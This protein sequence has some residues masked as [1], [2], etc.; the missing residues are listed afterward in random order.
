MEAEEEVVHPES[1]H[2]N[3][4]E[5][6]RPLMD[7]DDAQYKA[8]LDDVVNQYAMPLIGKIIGSK[9]K[10]Y[11]AAQFN[12]AEDFDVDDLCQE[13]VTNL[14]AYLDNW[15][16]NPNDHVIND[17]ND[18]VAK[19]AYNVYNSYLRRKYPLRHSLKR[20]IQ[21]Q[22]KTHGEFELWKVGHEKIA[23]LASW[24]SVD[25]LGA[26]SSAL[27]ALRQ[28][29]RAFFAERLRGQ[30]PDRLPLNELLHHLFSWVG[31]PV[32]IDLLV[33]VIAGLLGV[34][35][36][37]NRPNKDD[38]RTSENKKRKEKPS[39]AKPQEISQIEQ[40]EELQLIW[41]EIILLP[42]RQRKALLLNLKN[43]E[44]EGMVNALP[45]CGI[46]SM[47]KI[48]EALEMKIEE[49]ESLWDKLPL[50]DVK[51]GEMLGIEPQGVINLRKAARERLARRMVKADKMLK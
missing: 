12:W 42:I 38:E 5:R 23:G 13:S 16:Q 18:F 31:H 33:E 11:S 21:Y 20:R 48:A 17:L 28:D 47:T 29:A 8:L 30:S 26:Q 24:K 40:R 25:Q 19:I 36:Q 4:D 34:S 22:L 39:E 51:I 3:L 41:Q 9:L 32:E 43:R 37:P 2:F 10:V 35:D 49:L 15:R 14:I 1:D 45:M 7:V 50:P 6:L 27:A 46:V 44:G